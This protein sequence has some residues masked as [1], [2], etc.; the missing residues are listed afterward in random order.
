MPGR[1]LGRQ[2][3]STRP[4]VTGPWF[5]DVATRSSEGPGAGHGS[6][7][8]GVGDPGISQDASESL[9]LLR[10]FMHLE[11]HVV[12]ILVDCGSIMDVPVDCVPCLG[13]LQS[14]FEGIVGERP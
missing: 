5:W 12:G 2:E 10:D 13:S 8:P 1:S 11:G 6:K 4:L 7:L 3:P 9:R 14:S